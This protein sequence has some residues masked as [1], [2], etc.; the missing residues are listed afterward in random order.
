MAPLWHYTSSITYLLNDVFMSTQQ[1]HQLW[2]QSSCRSCSTLSLAPN[3][4]PGA[5]EALSKYLWKDIPQCDLLFI[6]IT[7][8]KPHQLCCITGSHT[9]SHSQTFVQRM[10][11]QTNEWV[12]EGS[13]KKTTKVSLSKV[14]LHK[15]LN[16]E[17]FSLNRY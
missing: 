13:G 12:N 4:S 11:K 3:K 1:D 8:S 7:Y 6:R 9:N 14:F 10:I 15:T 5:Q 16:L 17:C 2:E